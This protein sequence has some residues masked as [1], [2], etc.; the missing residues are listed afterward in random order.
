[1]LHNVL[2]TEGKWHKIGTQFFKKK[3]RELEMSSE[4]KRGG[5]PES[6]WD[7]FLSR[8]PLILLVVPPLPPLFLFHGIHL[9]VLFTCFSFVEFP[10]DKPDPVFVTGS[11]PSCPYAFQIILRWCFFCFSLERLRFLSPSS[12]ITNL[13]IHSLPLRHTQWEHEKDSEC[14]QLVLPLVKFSCIRIHKAGS[15]CRLHIGFP[16]SPA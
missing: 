12:F 6:S 8:N 1:M 11:D 2:Q 14:T 9:L 3:Y 13:L 5:G 15:F 16:N 4:K 7:S 10:F